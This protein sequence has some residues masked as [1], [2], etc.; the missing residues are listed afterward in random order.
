MSN[1]WL[2]HQPVPNKNNNTRNNNSNKGNKTAL[3]LNSTR[4]N[5]PK[6]NNNSRTLFKPMTPRKRGGKSVKVSRR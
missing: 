6:P 5:S 4:K 2:R 3:V 1:F